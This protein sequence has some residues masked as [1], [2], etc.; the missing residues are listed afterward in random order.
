MKSPVVHDECKCTWSGGHLEQTKHDLSS[1]LIL[2]YYGHLG[3]NK[4]FSND[5]Y[6]FITFDVQL[7]IENYLWC[8]VM[9]IDKILF[10]M[11]L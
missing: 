4:L 6:N 11:Q 9:F 5:I 10:R 2:M 3:D 7:S 1:Q 8:V